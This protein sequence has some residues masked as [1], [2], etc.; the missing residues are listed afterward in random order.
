LGAVFA[1]NETLHGQSTFDMQCLF[2][3]S[4]VDSFTRAF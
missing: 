3:D 2:N 1:F 4:E